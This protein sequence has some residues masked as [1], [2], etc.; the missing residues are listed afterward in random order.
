MEKLSTS[1]RSESFRPM[2]QTAINYSVVRKIVKFVT[3]IVTGLL[4]I[5]T[6]GEVEKFVTNMVAGLIKQF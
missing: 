4:N 3:K 6:V 5:G 1:P 2:Q